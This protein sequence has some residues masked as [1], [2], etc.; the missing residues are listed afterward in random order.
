MSDYKVDSVPAGLPVGT[1]LYYAAPNANNLPSEWKVCDG[2]WMSTTA[3][4]ELFA[5]I[6]WKYSSFNSNS[7]FQL[8]SMVGVRVRGATT[9]AYAHS[10]SN[11]L[12]TGNVTLSNSNLPSHSHGATNWYHN[13]YTNDNYKFHDTNGTGHLRYYSKQN[14]TH[15]DSN[16]L[17]IFHENDYSTVGGSANSVGSYRSSNTSNQGSGSSISLNPAFINFYAIIKVL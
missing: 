7:S 17:M 6:Q 2:S 12:G 11:G 15:D 3:F 14:G 1:I 4:P 9:F 16:H 8:P 10:A 5:L 13:H